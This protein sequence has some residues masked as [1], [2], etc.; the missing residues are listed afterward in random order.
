MFAAGCGGGG[1]V[2]DKRSSLWGSLGVFG[3]GG[4]EG[5]RGVEGDVEVRWECDVSA[6]PIYSSSFPF[7]LLSSFLRDT[8]TIRPSFRKVEAGI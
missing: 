2:G 1:G 7:L 5:G 4:D 8:C 6:Y 3:G